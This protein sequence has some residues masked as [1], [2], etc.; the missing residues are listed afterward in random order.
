M[1]RVGPEL[2]MPKLKAGELK[3]PAFF[4]DLFFDL[5]ER[6]LLPLVVLIVV[7]IA[8]APIL[9]KEDSAD[10][11]PVPPPIA[12]TGS[13][14]PAAQTLNV[15][16][17]EPGLRNYKKRLDHRSPV[18]PFKQRYTAPRLEGQLNEPTTTTT[19]TIT[20]SSGTTSSETGATSPPTESGGATPEAES[21]GGGEGHV[22]LYAYTINAQISRTEEAEDGSVEMSEPVVHENVRPLT[23]LPGE[24]APVVTY[25]GVNLEK[26]K[27][28]LMV[29]REAAIVSGHNRCAVRGAGTCELLEVEP[30]FPEILE[31]G[32][33]HVRYKFKIVKVDVVPAKH[34]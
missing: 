11:E 26:G 29:S 4:S 32:P 13:A 24:K 16:Q 33:N 18:N 34:S 1:K 28:L 27:I 2:K 19:S 9:L 15:A 17:A 21:G 31:Y 25:L 20:E 8:A 5:R 3:V 6:R 23:P 30:G 7:G 14:Q 10:P 22:K 12:S